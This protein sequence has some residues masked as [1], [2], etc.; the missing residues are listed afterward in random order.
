MKLAGM[1][2]HSVNTQ[3]RYYMGQE[4]TDAQA[5]AFKGTADLYSSKC[6]ILKFF[7][8]FLDEQ[9]VT[10]QHA[11]AMTSMPFTLARSILRA[12]KDLQTACRA[13]TNQLASKT[14]CRA[15]TN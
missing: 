5:Y 4:S 8:D 14:A 7:W 13:M 2:G 11:R 6:Q 10:N 12:S 15:M 1:M 9:S 3:E